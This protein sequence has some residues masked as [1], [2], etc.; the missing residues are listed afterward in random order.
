MAIRPL[1]A[2][3]EWRVPP[4]LYLGG[5]VSASTCFDFVAG[6][7]FRVPRIFGDELIYWEL[8]RS[9]A[10]TGHF[11][12]RGMGTS[13]YGVAYPAL[14]AVVQRLVG[15]ET[16]VYA[17]ARIVGA[18]M[19][20]LAAVP[21]FA[22]ASRVVTRRYA[23]GAAAFAVLIP[24]LVYTSTLMTE[25]AF[26]PAALTCVLL[27]VRALERPSAIRQ[28]VLLVAIGGTC[29]IR[30]QG[31][32][33]LPAYITA[34]VLLAVVGDG[35]LRSRLRNLLRELMP[36]LV[37]TAA[38]G[39]AVLAETIVRGV[40]PVGLLGA[41]GVLVKGY[42]PATLVKWAL[43]NLADLDLYVGVIPFA[44]FGVLLTSSLGSRD[45][46]ENVRRL[47][48]VTASVGV[49]LLASVVALSSSVSGLGRVHERNLFALAP[50]VFTVFLIWLSRG[51]PRPKRRA[52]I[53]A[54]GATILPLAIP[55]SA[56]RRPS[57]D[58]FAT[59]LWSEISPRYALVHLL[60]VV[61]AAML[62]FIFLRTSSQHQK[63]LLGAS[64]TVVLMTLLA[65]EVQSGRDDIPYRADAA[66]GSW[67]DAAVGPDAK[68][69]AIWLPPRKETAPT[70]QRVH[71]LW[72]NEFF[73]RSVI[74]VGSTAGRLP[75]G[76][77]VIRLVFVGRRCLV[78]HGPVPSPMFAVVPSDVSLDEPVVARS[79]ST[80]STLYKL[81][82]RPERRCLTHTS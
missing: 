35:S 34:A 68:V 23:F 53:V 7:P 9:L 18:V 42:P 76:L 41:Y 54:L 22:L 80:R 10:W 71:D 59:F 51:L 25:N 82:G 74:N 29:L 62:T 1:S 78:A 73:N 63:L 47:V 43:A 81:G 30:T 20:S 11:T 15:D 50:L 46:P 49:F 56:I 75:D 24:S 61:V 33:L 13:G 16:Q 52:G 3:R 26:Y 79:S 38:G 32:V 44:A 2:L 4:W 70:S 28:V 69:L 31:I 57:G 77:P 37:V 8:S 55:G 5:L 48:V 14:L 21:V 66:A 65:A 12:V 27:M 6:I 60:M 72:S 45:L 17:V 67:I 39:A 36:T 40:S 19:F 58:A 64:L